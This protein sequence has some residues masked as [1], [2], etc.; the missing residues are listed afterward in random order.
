MRL[1]NFVSAV[2]H[3]RFAAPGPIKNAS[4][5]NAARRPL[6]P[7]GSPPRKC[8]R[9]ACPLPSR[10]RSLSPWPSSSATRRRCQAREAREEERGGHERR[11]AC[12]WKCAKSDS[13]VGSDT[14]TCV[15]RLANGSNN[16]SQISPLVG[17]PCLM[18]LRTWMSCSSNWPQNHPGN[19]C[20]GGD[21]AIHPQSTLAR[22]AGKWNNMVAGRG[23]PV[24]EAISISAWRFNVPSI[25]ERPST[26]PLCT[27]CAASGEELLR[28][29]R[30]RNR[31]ET[32]RAGSHHKPN[33][34]TNTCMRHKRR[35][36]RAVTSAKDLRY[37]S[38]LAG[39][40]A[41]RLVPTRRHR[42]CY[43]PGAGTAGADQQGAP[44]LQPS[45]APPPGAEQSLGGGA[46]DARAKIRRNRRRCPHVRWARAALALS[47]SLVASAR[48]WP[49]NQQA[50]ARG[51]PQTKHSNHRPTGQRC[52][53]H[54]TQLVCHGPSNVAAGC[55]LRA[56]MDHLRKPSPRCSRPRSF[57]RP[58]AKRWR[59]CPPTPGDRRRN[60][61]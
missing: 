16:N 10:S 27:S 33:L 18:P 34:L 37:D 9:A 2:S 7:C 29:A 36:A 30:Q 22:A 32:I 4:K 41:H 24:I 58:T 43:R 23:A 59:R 25:S 40:T 17:H 31:S 13:K 44:L 28:R 45:A 38:G 3:S 51:Q 61:I 15:K 14:T 46:R 54:S 35:E 12:H 1:R 21:R 55:P 57:C 8:A 6:S 5:W 20:A 39:K 50:R 60:Q 47:L 48:L 11:R 53:H 56:R 19:L 52:V 42:L 49:G 26:H